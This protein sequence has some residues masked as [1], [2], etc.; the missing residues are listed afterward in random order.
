MIRVLIVDD[1][2]TTH[3]LLLTLL[4]GFP[5]VQVV[6]VATDGDAAV[7][8]AAEIRPD[9]ITMDIRM[10]KLDGIACIRAIM[11][12]QPTPIVVLCADHDDPTLN[13]SFN[14]LKAGAVEVIEKP[15]LRTTSEMR[16]FADHVRTTIHLM[17]EIKVVR[18]LVDESGEFPSLVSGSGEKSRPARVV[19]DA[20]GICS[21]TGGPAALEYLFRH[22]PASFP[23]PIVVVQHITEGF[24]H[25]LVE[26][27]RKSSRL[28][29]KIAE[30]G[31]LAVGG[32]IYFAPERVHLAYTLGGVLGFR[33]DAP[34]RSHKPSG[35]VL[36]SSLAMSLGTRAMGVMLTGM[37]EDGA[38]GLED[39]SRCGGIVLSQDEKS[40][41]VFGMP[42]VVAER[43]VA[44]EVVSLER[45]AEQMTFWVY[46]GIP[47]GDHSA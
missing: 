15:R 42:R 40:S 36:F 25:G 3:Q 28:K 27:L 32:T 41:V 39:I 37:G 10:P 9:L 43:N 7:R 23:V 44:R 24:L 35:E 20:V 33:H 46:G 1:S 21:S 13:V 14:A 16:A 47:D 11:R 31:E 26:W 6:G 17:A 19:V 45:M 38:D 8:L 18:Q 34:I 2:S 5:D 29:V 4:S 12:D 30:D 22:L